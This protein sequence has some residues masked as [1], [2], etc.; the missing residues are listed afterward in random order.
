MQIC[1][2]QKGVLWVEA[3]LPGKPAHGSRPWDGTNAIA[4]LRDGLVAL[5][6]RFPTP[7]E[8]AWLTTVVPTVVQ[9]GATSNRLPEEVRLVFDVRHVPEDQ[10]AQII[11]AMQECFAGKVQLIR[12]GS[13]LDT[14]PNDDYVQQ[15][16]ATLRAV[17]GEPPQLYREHFASDAR[18][19]SDKR[20]PAVCFGPVG[21][22]LHSDEEWVEIDSLVQLYAVLARF[23]TM[24]AA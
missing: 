3:I 9:G 21:A 2:A 1:Y 8:P 12:G 24:V 20:I 14:D 16:A 22:G 7:D 10:P 13:P 5:E 23:V 19:Y 6:Q 17:A 11:A 18:F 4:E 15:L